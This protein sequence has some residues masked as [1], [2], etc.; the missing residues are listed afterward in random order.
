MTISTSIFQVFN[1]SKLQ[2]LLTDA[3][4]GIKFHQLNSKP[5]AVS[6]SQPQD[7]QFLVNKK[8]IYQ[9]S[10]QNWIATEE[11][12]AEEHRAFRQHV[13][14]IERVSAG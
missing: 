2:Q 7:D 5:M 8:L 4:A 10:S 6:I 14:A 11:L 12:T 9:D 13:Q 1:M 3:N